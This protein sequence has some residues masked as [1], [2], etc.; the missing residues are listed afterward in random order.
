MRDDL[1]RMRDMLD[2]IGRIEKYASRGRDEF[3]R[4]DWMQVWVVHHLQIIGEAARGL[5]EAMR[6]RMQDVPWRKVVGMRHILVHE[7]FQIDR[8]LVWTVVVNDL[9]IMMRSIE[10]EL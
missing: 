9:P 2:A 6:D 3:D 7:Y 8:D 10:Q 1:Q 4:H 5:S